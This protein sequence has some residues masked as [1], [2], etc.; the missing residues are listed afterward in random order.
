MKEQYLK[1]IREILRAIM[2]ILSIG[3]GFIGILIFQNFSFQTQLIH[4]RGSIG[5]IPKVTASISSILP[6]PKLEVEE[7]ESILV[8][9]SPTALEDVQNVDWYLQKP[10]PGGSSF[11]PYMDANTLTSRGSDQYKLK[12]KYELDSKTGIW[13]VDGRYCVAL[14]SY[15]T[16]EIGTYV[17][18][19]LANGTIIPCILADCKADQHTDSTNRQNP[20]GSVVEFIVNEGS[21]CRKARKRG[22]CSHSMDGWKGD[23]AGV[24]VYE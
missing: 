12:T 9:A 16:T 24:V 19:V 23:V 11:K 6:E 13:T 22:D 4:I 18:I 3:V 14:G 15:Y 20:N 7:N 17:D 2:V 21:L 10:A 1:E 5:S 8:S